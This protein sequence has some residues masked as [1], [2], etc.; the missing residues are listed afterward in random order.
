LRNLFA[1]LDNGEAKNGTRRLLEEIRSHQK[2]MP[3]DCRDDLTFGALVVLYDMGKVRA[4]RLVR[5]ERWSLVYGGL[6]FLVGFVIV[7][8]HSDVPWLTT[9]FNRIFGI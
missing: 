3:Q 6:L 9:F 7:A 8:L 2:D 1:S 4:K 5:L